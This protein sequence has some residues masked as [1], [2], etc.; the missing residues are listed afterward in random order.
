[1]AFNE[2]I[3]YNFFLNSTKYKSF[4]FRYVAI[5]IIIQKFYCFN[6]HIKYHLI[7]SLTFFFLFFL[8]NH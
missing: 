6:N 4:K 3:I 2:D 1:M 7:F 5:I 8:K